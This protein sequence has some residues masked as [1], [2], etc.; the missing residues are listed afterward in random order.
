VT[1]DELQ[2]WLDRYVEAWKT[3]KPA[4]IEELFTEDAE[5][6]YHPW[7]EPLQGR[8][9][10]VADWINPGG[11]PAQRDAPGTFDAS[12]APYAIEG[13]LVVAVGTTTYYKDATRAEVDRAYHNVYLMQFD[14]AN[15]CRSF[16]EHF[17]PL[18]KQKA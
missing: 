15:N 8:A 6:R 12:Y 5:Y 1:H 9:A 14:E 11:N 18:P 3:Y 13:D 17:M 7:D 16:T 2:G 4:D 10:I